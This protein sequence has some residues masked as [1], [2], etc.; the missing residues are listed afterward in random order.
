MRK[1]NDPALS[2][3]LERLLEDV[4]KSQLRVTEPRVAILEVLLKHH[5][6]FT[7]EEIHKRLAKDVCDL[8]TIYRS[9]ASLE[10]TGIL[11]RCEFGDGTSRYEL[12]EHKNHHHH[13]VICKLCKRVEVLDD[14][15]LKEI[16]H[17][18]QKRGFTEITH[19]LEFFGVCPKCQKQS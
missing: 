18:A 14:C 8:A 12:S 3:H 4:R 5:G 11:R 1:K 16:D 13:H 9:L 7:V 17:F 2:S 15:E 10:K 6:P 19:S